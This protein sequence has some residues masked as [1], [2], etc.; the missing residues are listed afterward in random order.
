M[1]PIPA[2]ALGPSARVT[3]SGS[4]FGSSAPVS[5]GVAYTSE[6]GNSLFNTPGNILANAAATRTTAS[7]SHAGG[8]APVRSGV[9]YTSETGSL[10]P[11][12]GSVPIYA[13]RSHR[14]YTPAVKTTK[15]VTV[16]QAAPKP[17]PRTS[18]G[19]NM[20]MR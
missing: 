13:I 18:V 5:S 17:K 19:H 6:T 7:G 14:S 15:K 11:S 8:S 9:A 3:A 16:H 4:T 20:L 10:M 2:A 1:V 12:G